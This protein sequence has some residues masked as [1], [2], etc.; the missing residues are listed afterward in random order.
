MLLLVRKAAPKAAFLYPGPV[1]SR[2][3]DYDRERAAQVAT[4]VS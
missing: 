2:A 1:N 3:G 4:I